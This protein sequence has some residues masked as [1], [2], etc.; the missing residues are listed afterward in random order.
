MLEVYADIWCPFAHVGLRAAARERLRLGRNDVELIIRAWPLELVN[1]V[2]LDP[3]TTAHHVADLRAQVAPDLF[4]RFDPT[5]FPTTTIPAL[6]LAS[7]AYRLSAPL[8]E[9]V[10]FALREA[11]FERGLDVGK[12]EVLA[13]IAK[14]FGLDPVVTFDEAP[15]LDEWRSGQQRGVKGSPHFFCGDSEAFCPALDIE[16]DAE[17]HLRL[18]RSSQELAEF[19]DGCLVP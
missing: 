14:F 19:L 5:T 15:V 9:A 7:A 13:E 16:R 17:G 1:A 11:I 2:P 12:P 4:A 8:G 10:S 3:V 6:A 18:R